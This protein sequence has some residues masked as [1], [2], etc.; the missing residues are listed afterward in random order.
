MHKLPHDS[1]DSHKDNRSYH[2]NH[3]PDEVLLVPLIV[4]IAVL[5]FVISYPAVLLIPL[6]LIVI[7]AG[8]KFFRWS[9]RGKAIAPPPPVVN[10]VSPIIDSRYISD[11][12][13]RAVL[14]RDQ[15][16]CRSCGS[17]SYLELDHINP[18]SR[19]GAT[20]YENLQV[21]CRYCNLSK[22]NR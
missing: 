6:G 11:P 9:Q 4:F 16:R 17:Q 7:W 18:L 14:A 5:G 8:F 1:A 21:L 3:F 2:T 22:G 19:G 10:T 20:S 15:Y 13:R 12:I